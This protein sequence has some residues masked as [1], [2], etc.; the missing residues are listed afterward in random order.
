MNGRLFAWLARAELAR[1]PGR[2]ALS[3]LAIA[4]GLALGYAVHLVNS[5]AL[6]EFGTAMRQVNGS[7]DLQVR[8]RAGNDFDEQVYERLSASG[9]IELGSPVIE[10]EVILPGT[11]DRLRILGLDVLRAAR[12]TPALIGRSDRAGEGTEEGAGDGTA[13][14]ARLFDDQAIYLSQ[15]A[16][17]VLHRRVGDTLSLPI[18]GR[19][20]NL[21]IAGSLP[22]APA[23]SLLGSME[24]AGAQWH[25]NRLG[26]LSRIDL[27]LAEGVTPQ[28]AQRD[29]PAVLGDTVQLISEDNEMNRAGDLSRAYRINLDML[30]LMALFTGAYLVYATQSLSVARRRAQ[31]A[32][33]RVLGVS[34][35][36]LL[37]QI[38]VEGAVLG[39]IGAA[40]GLAAGTLLARTALSVLGGDLGGGYFQ[41]SQPQL[42]W[43]PGAALVFF[44]LGLSAAL[45]G[46]LL[47]AREAARAQPAVALKAGADP[48]DPRQRPRIDIAVALLAGGALSSVLPPLQGVPAFAYLAMGLLLFG[49][50]ALMPALARLLLGLLQKRR[51][52]PLSLALACDRLWGAPSQATVAMCGIVASVSLIVAMGV[53][54]NSFRQ[55]VDDWLG[56]LLP[57]DLY[58]RVP[59]AGDNPL[60]DAVLQQ[61]LGQLPGVA[62]T[63]FQRFLP[64]RLN[65]DRPAVLLLARTV[66][67][68][69]ALPLLRS[70]PVPA[71][72]VPVWGSEAMV[73]LYGWQP[74]QTITLPLG[75]DY[76]SARF[77]VA[78]IWRDY[79]RQHGSI[80]VRDEDYT[81]LSGD[82][83]RSDAAFTLTPGSSAAALATRI[84]AAVP[85]ALAERLEF[86]EPGDI[87][88]SSLRIFDRSFA[89]TYVLQAVAIAIGLL[90]VSATFSAQTLARI[91]EFGMLRHIGVVRRQ[92][93]GM[94]A[95]EGLLLGGVGVTAG[96]VLGLVLSQ[97]LIHVVNPQSFHW[98]MDTHIPW[99]MLASVALGLL[100]STVTAAVLAGRHALSIDAVRAV[101][102]DW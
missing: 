55:S 85:Q 4:L 75:Q 57:A 49:G 22:G 65:P 68:S 40:L 8:A 67:N 47:P 32:L 81:R 93:V 78:G 26:R 1:T 17:K 14:A 66:D 43:T 30:A 54:I 23:G 41:N 5:S 64:L 31:L 87:R 53:M 37:Q 76:P 45:L 102:E 34:R 2:A 71:G 20:A 73:D 98:T 36:G 28:Q 101:R 96:L 7:A 29:L 42:N 90:G 19:I 91:K 70:T 46:S 59:G 79:A 9:L 56:Q 89:V 95:F 48:M 11:S 15:H 94:L 10:A 25:L 77:F 72:H 39:A 99:A 62:K 21:R 44:L 100:V 13:N 61:Q 52:R 35:A 18:G 69:S 63:S 3:I 58:V 92:I 97:V 86:A 82:S 84:R 51:L 27:K 16:L 50:I 60:F 83:K 24:I 88:R 38:L 74:G 80:I 6:D 33:L 12:V